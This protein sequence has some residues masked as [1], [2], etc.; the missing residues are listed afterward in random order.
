MTISLT[1]LFVVAWFWYNSV[2]S[3]DILNDGSLRFWIGTLEVDVPFAKIT[4]LRRLSNECSL[5]SPGL[6]PH[7]GYMTCPDDG[8]AIVTTVPSMPLFMWPRSAGT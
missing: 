2:R 7:R 5:V 1:N 8:V 4:D 6:L 3:V